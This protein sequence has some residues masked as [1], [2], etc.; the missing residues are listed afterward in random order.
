MAVQRD[1]ARADARARRAAAGEEAVYRELLDSDGPTV[2]TGYTHGQDPATVVAVMD[3]AD[4]TAE[5]VLDRTPFY[6]ESGGQVGDTGTIT[7]ETGRATVT[8]TQIAL[9]GLIVH[10]ARV[11]G[12]L[13]PG[14]D[15][16]AAI[17]VS[18]RDG[19]RRNHT[20]THLLHS[21]LRQ[22]LGD[23]V[24]QQS[25][26][27]AP[28][29]LRF[30]FS[31]PQGVRPEEMSEVARL[32]NAQVIGDEAV[33]I[34]ETSK[35][36]AEA[37]GALA[38]F[39]DKYGERVRVVRA[40]SRSTELCGGTHVDALG[41]IGPVTVMSES[42]IGSNTRRIE[43]VTGA[44][45]LMVAEERQRELAEAAQLLRVEPGG[46]VEALE[47]LIERQRQTDKELQR[48]RG[49][50]LD[51]RAA[52]LA[53]AARDGTVV[54]RVDD[55]SPDQLRDLA[56]AVR[57][58]GPE[59]VV[60]AGTPDGAKVAVAVASGGALDAGATVKELAAVVGGGGGG[61]P[62]LAVAGGREVAKID[63][64]LAEARRTL[65]GRSGRA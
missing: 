10:R 60:I 2:F 50:S 21:A 49:A 4:G 63:E 1:R 51:A 61:S 64:M 37:M 33:E 17:D 53:G 7:T 16:L 65:A 14:Q 44:G 57:R 43:A 25:S 27:V 40:G 62:E 5:I 31:H 19:A 3:G 41:M 23:H 39:G 24:R 20:G 26:Y 18:R 52:E 22:V 13:F 42:S 34:I 6:A 56:Q 28:D 38:F 9:P 58:Q 12:E 59:V 11:E 15:A 35:A 30:D 47:R 45:S 36:E 46:V 54:T 32:V 8:D 48:L 29:R 55:L